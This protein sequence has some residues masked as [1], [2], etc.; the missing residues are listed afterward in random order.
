M[1]VTAVGGRSGSA[2]H[3]PH[4][5]GSAD[6]RCHHQPQGAQ[7]QGGGSKCVCVCVYVC[8]CVIVLSSW[9]SRSLP[10]SLT[11]RSTSL[12]LSSLCV[13]VPKEGGVCPCV[14]VRMCVKGKKVCV[15]KVASCLYVPK[16]SGVCLCLCVCMCVCY[17]PRMDPQTS[18]KRQ[19][20]HIK[21]KCVW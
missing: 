17:G 8:V 20:V 14:W 3:H 4:L 2:L 13:C 5:H 19:T 16:E 9:I 21:C 11:A 10:S 12:R 1:V 15:C 7:A 18:Y 6:H